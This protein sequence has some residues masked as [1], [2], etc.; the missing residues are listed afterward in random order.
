M[1]PCSRVRP[2]KAISEG[3]N[4]LV[5]VETQNTGGARTMKH[6]PKTVV[7]LSKA[8]VG[9]EW[10]W[11]KPVRQAVCAAEGRAGDKGSTQSPSKPHSS[12]P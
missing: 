3:A 8:V 12:I 1:E 5:E 11:P 9:I 7:V 6:Q 4:P 10:S 2:A